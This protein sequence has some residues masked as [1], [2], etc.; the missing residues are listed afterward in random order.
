MKARATALVVALVVGF[1]ACGGPSSPA[2]NK[3]ASAPLPAGVA[4][5]LTYQR[6]DTSSGNIYTLSLE[7]KAERKITDF[8]S[9]S[10]ATFS[11]R[12]PDGSRLAYVR[13][14]GMG[15][16]LWLSNPD[17]GDARKIVD[18]STS[19][20]TIERPQWTPDGQAIIYTYH[21]FLIEGGAIKGEIFRAER[22]DPDSGSREELAPDAE[23]PS[24]APDGTLT[25]IR[26][27]RSGQQLMLLLP[28]GTEK[29]LVGSRSFLNLAAPRFSRDGKRISFTAV[30]EGPKV[31][32]DTTPSAAEA[33]LLSLT[34]QLPLLGPLAAG[35]GGGAG[36]RLGPGVAYAHGE[37]WDIWVAE[38]SGGVRRLTKLTEDEPMTAWGPDD[39]Y[40]AVSGGTGVYVIDVATGQPT[41]LAPLGGFGGIDWTR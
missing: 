8:P 23:G 2:A 14:E 24:M 35:L 17:G 39:Q 38:V 3:P 34:A 12:S 1:A 7:T 16:A 37:P 19:S 20:T 13:V 33:S 10:P 32:Q 31:G 26:T 15:S 22:V 27:T 29:V 21:G 41:Q 28:D 4:G 30:G 40:V 25:F 9:T 6:L 5:V 11:A 18:E 36:L